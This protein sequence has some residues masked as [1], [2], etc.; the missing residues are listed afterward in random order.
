MTMTVKGECHGANSATTAM[1]QAPR[2]STLSFSKF[3]MLTSAT[4]S[5]SNILIDPLIYG[6][7]NKG[8]ST[9]RLLENFPD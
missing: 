3:I 4:Y 5:L 9:S 8:R 1:A 2:L 7:R 6:H